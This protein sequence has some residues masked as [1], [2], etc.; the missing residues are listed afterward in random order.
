[1]SSASLSYV[2]TR[3][4]WRTRAKCGEARADGECFSY[5]SSVLKNFQA[6]TWLNN[7]REASFFISFT[8]CIVSC[9]R[10]YR[11]R[12]LRA[13]YLTVH[14]CD[15][16]CVLYGNIMKSFWPIMARTF[17]CWRRCCSLWT[18]SLFWSK[19]MHFFCAPSPSCVLYNKTEH[20]QGFS[21]CYLL[22]KIWRTTV[23]PKSNNSFQ[24][25]LLYFFIKANLTLESTR[26]SMSFYSL[27]LSFQ[28]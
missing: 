2:G 17:L 13:L 26:T 15:V 1:M 4:F 12:R 14:S 18:Y 7:A 27:L 21:F 8:K 24:S 22:R 11:W 28:R 5:F 10:S 3:E 23:S 9:A 19:V 6:L 16:R 20:R 25:R